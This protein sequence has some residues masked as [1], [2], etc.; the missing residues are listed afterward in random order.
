[1]AL[2]KVTQFDYPVIDM[3]FHIV[4]PPTVFSEH[5]DAKTLERARDVFAKE[6]HALWMLASG[7][8]V[9]TRGDVYRMHMESAE[10]WEQ[11]RVNW[12]YMFPGTNDAEV[13]LWCMDQ[14][15]IDKGLV[16]NTFGAGV[17]G[18]TDMEIAEATCRAYNDWLHEF[19]SA[20]PERL[21]P[22]ALLPCGDMD[23]A[24][25][26]LERTAAMGFKGAVVPGSTGAPARLS[27]SYWDP[28]FS[29]MQELGWPLCCHA[30]F[31]PGIDSASQWLL[32]AGKGDDPEFGPVFWS[33]HINLSFMLDNIV[34]LGE[35]TL[36]GMC[37]KFPNLNVY[38]I[39][40]GHSW[41]GEAL[42]RLDKMFHCPPNDPIFFPDWKPKAKTPPSEIFERQLYVPFEGGDQHYMADMSFKALAK[43]LI[44]ASDIPHWDADGPWEGVGAMRALKVSREVEETVMGAN[45]AKLLGVPYEKRVGTSAKAR[46]AA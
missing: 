17:G 24:V 23:R 14:E 31:N 1:M 25:K 7:Q 26:E 34:T 43:N 44:W 15:G 16:R 6:A 22:E 11:T 39:E 30:T 32:G 35:I 19:C 40:A 45:A 29:R 2:E 8:Y 18:V 36:G 37:D 41:I 4:E 42:Y 38:F 28:L 27:S 9:K 10:A 12:D 3:D 21:L 46:A 13:R 5:M 20:D 33:M